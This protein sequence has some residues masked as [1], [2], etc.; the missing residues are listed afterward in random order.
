MVEVE[1][2]DASGTEP[3]DGEGRGEMAGLD[4]DAEGDGLDDF[5]GLLDLV[6][7][8]GD[9][10]GDGCLLLPTEDEESG[11]EMAGRAV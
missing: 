4:G 3:V 7:E 5:E 8:A 10:S 1:E 11:D 2:P 9:A 6:S